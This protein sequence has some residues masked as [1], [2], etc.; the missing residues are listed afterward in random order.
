[1]A[2][3]SDKHRQFVIEMVNLGLTKKAAAKAAE[4]AGFSSLH[5]YKLMRDQRILD[6]L[7]EESGKQL[8]G[9]VVVGVQTL[10][11]IAQDRDHK[12]RFK[13][14]KELAAI[15]GFTAEHKVT[16]QHVTRDLKDMISDIRSMANDLG[17]DGEQLIRAAGFIGI[18]EAGFAEAESEESAPLT[19]LN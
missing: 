7:R 9:G 18:G 5:G 8:A 6:A 2:A 17:I 3:L 11:D 15:N 19:R 4:S 10:I 13:A 1:M 12:D 16:V 14:A